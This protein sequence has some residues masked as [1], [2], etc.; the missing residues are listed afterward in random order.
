MPKNKYLRVLLGIAGGIFSLLLILFIYLYVVATVQPP[1]PD[2]L[3]SLELNPVKTPDG[4]MTIHN[5]WFR[6]SQSGLYELY[7]EGNPFER[8]V[9][10]GKL[11]RELV[12]YQEEVFTQQIHRLVPNTLYLE[13]LKYFVGWFNR[14]LE[15]Q[16]LPEYKMEIFGVSESA[17]H[18]FDDIAPPYHRLLN[19]H[20]AHDIGH[21]L[22][23]MSFVGCTSFG[24]WGTKSADSTLLIGR[25][26]DFYVGQDFAR[27]KIIAF[28]NPDQG[29]KFMMVTWGGMTG[30]LSGM[31]DQG[32]TVTINAA[33]SAIPS[34]S[35]TPVSIVAREILQYAKNI[36]EARHIAEQRK[37]F[38]SE[39]F[40]VGSAFDGKAAVI[41]KT[42]SETGFY[43]SGKDYII[44]ANHFQSELLSNTELNLEHMQTSPSPY[45]HNRMEELLNQKE[46]I[47]VTDAAEILRNQLG[48]GGKDIGLGNEKAINQLIS[49]H[50]II[51][52]PER[53]KVWISTSPYQLGK[54]ICYDLNKVFSSSPKT[55]N[56]EISDST[57]TISEDPFLYSLEFKNYQKFVQFRFPFSD[58]SNLNP[59]SLV[60]WNTNSY[61]SYMLGG[62]HFFKQ[63]E[64]AKAQKFYEL[65][66][67][68]EVSSTQE[69]NYMMNQ[70]K[71]CKEKLQ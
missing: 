25:N 62:D 31:N 57:F 8:G 7:V 52:Q 44:C 27:D 45:R 19:Y 70:I 60:Q 47:S 24:V 11:T 18:E 3:S 69:A 64:Y 51:F 50:A 28:Y 14:N 10:I 54:F 15:D 63:K 29:H 2:D 53:L 43:E 6:Q 9:I 55:D 42:E 30:V 17:S 37:V 49:H 71:I 46:K 41:E 33:K 58:R 61:L 48:L 68:K 35:A 56:V 67:G 26:F 66:L 32:L 36:S 65:G 5:S 40:L 12:H 34:G 23:N 22:Q 16:I 20:A 38:V 4:L 39:S 1:V 13:F 21:A 59:D